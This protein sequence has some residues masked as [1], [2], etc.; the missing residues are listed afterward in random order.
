MV[1]SPLGFVADHIEVLY[2]LDIEAREVC[3]TE[4]LRMARAS[5]VNDHP[6][7]LDALADTVAI[8]VQHY[9]RG[10]P[11]HGAA[12]DAAGAARATAAAT[13]IT[14]R[15]GEGRALPLEKIP[16]PRLAGRGPGKEPI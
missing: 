16:S 1:L 4:G 2:D 15:R 11:L 6:K 12:G 7:F 14:F 8:K 13:A 3:D 9:W 5:A 10:S